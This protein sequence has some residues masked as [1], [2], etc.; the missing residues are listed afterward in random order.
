MMAGLTGWTI[1][2]LPAGAIGFL[3]LALFVNS[4][5][6]YFKRRASLQAKLER[7]KKRQRKTEYARNDVLR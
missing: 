1:F 3:F 5:R 7:Q 4:A 6:L 2:A